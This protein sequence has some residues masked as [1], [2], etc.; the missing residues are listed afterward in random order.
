MGPNRFRRAHRATPY[1]PEQ[2]PDP[3]GSGDCSWCLTYTLPTLLHGIYIRLAGYYEKIAAMSVV[4]AHPKTVHHMFELSLRRA[5]HVR[6]FTITH[7]DEHGWEVRLE[8]DA[9]VKRRA[10]YQDW[11]R[12][13]R[14]KALFEREAM[15]LTE[16]GW[17]VGQATNP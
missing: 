16:N 6:R 8:E 14:A 17:V 1:H 11:H 9:A 2:T 3:L 5:G 4:E 13:E 15:E 10:L 7:Q 12:V